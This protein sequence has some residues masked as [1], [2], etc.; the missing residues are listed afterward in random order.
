M[1]EEDTR[2]RRVAETQ[3]AVANGFLQGEG[4]YVEDHTTCSPTLKPLPHPVLPSL[5]AKDTAN[6]PVHILGH[7]RTTESPGAEKAG[8]AKKRKLDAALG[9]TRVLGSSE[10]EK[11]AKRTRQRSHAQ[12]QERLEC[13]DEDRHKHK[14][15]T[16]GLHL[17]DISDAEETAWLG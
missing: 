13:G 2:V 9:R 10:H 8:H 4:E 16:E 15:K 3:F 1:K 11:L 6:T 17:R 12:D 14:H 5:P 7:G